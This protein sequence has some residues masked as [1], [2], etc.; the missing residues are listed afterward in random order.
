MNQRKR[1]NPEFPWI[2]R[3]L[4]TETQD[5]KGVIDAHFSTGMR[6]VIRR[7]NEGVD[8]RTPGKLYAAL[9][10]HGGPKNTT[11]KLHRLDLGRMSQLEKACEIILKREKVHFG[12]VNDIEFHF[13]FFV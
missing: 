9:S 4:H 2:K 12:R 13:F 3:F 6:H 7:I 8:V 10:S 11:V 5:G 1:R